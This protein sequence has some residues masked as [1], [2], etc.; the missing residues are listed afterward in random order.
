MYLD[1]S[2]PTVL[3]IST[4]CTG[5]RGFAAL[6]RALTPAA[7]E[8]SVALSWPLAVLGA[9]AAE[10]QMAGSRHFLSLIHI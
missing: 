7:W 5:M 3:I 1:A 9:R 4:P 8:R 2:E 6:N 10:V